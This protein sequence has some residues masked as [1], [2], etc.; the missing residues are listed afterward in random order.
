M[1]L[2]TEQRED[3]GMAKGYRANGTNGLWARDIFSME[4][5]ERAFDFLLEP[6]T[7]KEETEPIQTGSSD[8]DADWEETESSLSDGLLWTYLN[9][10][11]HVA[12]LTPEEECEIGK[13]IEEADHKTKSV[14]LESPRAMNELLRISRQLQAETVGVADVINI[15]TSS[16][17]KDDDYR[18]ETISSISAL[19]KL[20]DLNDEIR[21]KLAGVDPAGRSGLENDLKM[22]EA[23]R[24][25]ILV[26]LKLKKKILAEI[27]RKIQRQTRRMENEEALAARKMLDRLKEIERTL[28]TVRNRLVQANL[29]LV[30]SNAKRYVNRGLSFLDLV[31]EGNLG[32]MR[33]AERYEYQKGFRFSTYATWWIKQSISRAI[34]DSARTIRVP[35]HALQTANVIS[36][37]ASSLTRELGREPSLEEISSQADIST[38]KIRRII[39]ATNRTISIETPVGDDESILIDFLADRESRS[40]FAEVE[41]ISLKEEVNKVLSTLTPKEEKVIRMRLGIGEM[42]DCTLEEVADVFGLTRERI[43]QIEAKALRKLQ[44]PNRKKML[45]SF[46][47]WASG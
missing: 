46:R 19:K 16:P 6:D 17:G 13:S 11:G 31:Q 40:P 24:E 2:D 38:E 18:N 30:I 14:L 42:T 44:S 34:A 20:Y 9:D 26:G 22:V 43:R 8:R 33:A 39:K 12:L 23:G 36:K 35:V 21:R 3:A 47:D 45:E 41:G 29:R 25:E 5:E 28:R 4:D 7:E 32:L 15:D 1:N 27:A 37:T 10:I